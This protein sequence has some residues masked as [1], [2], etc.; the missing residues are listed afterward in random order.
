MST[1][2]IDGVVAVVAAV[3]PGGCDRTG[4]IELVAACQRARGALDALDARLAMALARLEEP[5]AATL[6]D[7][8]RRA[9]K[10]AQA[11]ADRGRAC[12]LLPSLHDALAVGAV[13]AG[14]ADA[15]ARAASQLDH[16]ATTAFKELEGAIV[17]AASRSSVESFDREMRDLSRRLS[18]DDGLRHHQRLRQQRAL[19]RWVDRQ[20]GMCHTHVLLDPEADA[21]LSVSLDAAIATERAKPDV[22]GR[23]FEQLK[24]DAFVALVTGARG[25]RRVPEV[26]VL[27]DLDTL[28]R[29]LHARS[30]CQT[31]DGQPLPPDAVRRMAC[32]AD[33][34]PIVLDGRGVS[35]DVGRAKRMAT[36]A[37]RAAL[38]AM[39]AT[40]AHPHCT[41]RFGDCA[42]HHVAEW[43]FGGVTALANLLPLCNEH[44]HLV[45][46][47]GWAA[48]P[49]RRPHD[50]AAAAG[51]LVV[52]PRLDGGR[53]SQRCQ[54][55]GRRAR[56]RPGT[57]P[58]H[59]PTEQGAG[60]LIGPTGRQA[61]RSLC[62][63]RQPGGGRGA[64]FRHRAVPRAG[65]RRR[66]R[67]RS[68]R[69]R[70]GARRRQRA[71]RPLRVL[72]RSRFRRPLSGGT[73]HVDGGARGVPSG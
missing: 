38:R 73:G 47:G 67:Q 63:P 46:E 24:A 26:A 3:D 50:R 35:L 44:H 25:E 71:R 41:V 7:G 52:L 5:V 27:I 21:T 62:V 53:R 29:G 30:V 64:R 8:G 43:T 1:A 65:Q 39:Y 59:R 56:P 55:R 51:R 18:Q 2:A 61:T 22:D 48:V 49:V 72:T 70:R 58:C 66:V 15:V 17:A 42:I 16:D 33:I 10:E 69:R 36:S 31:A 28:R 12:A 57:A 37:Q 60:G 19:R 14:H 34:L 20:T 32:S 45:H 54:R 6:T 13:S 11:A 23:T 68:S 9:V 4:V 40:C